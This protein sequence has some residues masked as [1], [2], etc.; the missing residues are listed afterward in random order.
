MVSITTNNQCNPFNIYYTWICLNLSFFFF[1]IILFDIFKLVNYIYVCNQG[2]G[3]GV[4][5]VR[6]LNEEEIKWPPW[7]QPLL[8]ARFFVQCKVHADSNKSECNMYCLDCMN[9]ALCSSCLA[10][11]KDHRA[12]QVKQNTYKHQVPLILRIKSLS[13]NMR[14]QSITYLFQCGVCDC[15]FS[16]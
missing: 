4:V 7:L 1:L 2:D 12:I 15:V 8:Q 6:S 3:E 5:G 9:G 10:S 14:L 13:L 11:H 16:L